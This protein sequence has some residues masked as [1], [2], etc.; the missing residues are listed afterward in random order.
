MKQSLKNEIC[1][2]ICLIILSVFAAPFESQAAFQPDW[3]QS[4]IDGSLKMEQQYY[5]A[6]FA[7]YKGEK[8]AYD[9]LRL[10]KDRALDDLSYQLSV[11]I[12]SKFEDRIIKKG[13][14]EEEHITSSLFISTRKVLSGVQEKDK[15]TDIRS[16]RR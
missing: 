12:K 4:H 16:H 1:L 11:S 5:G 6:G 2:A 7:G 10:A 8:P 9:T 13:D 14:F 3:V 15:W